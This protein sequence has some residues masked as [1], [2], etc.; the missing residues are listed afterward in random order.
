M[1]TLSPATTPAP[2]PAPDDP[3]ALEHAWL[4]WREARRT[5]LAD[6]HGV[7]SLT[8]HHWLLE[9]AATLDA[10][11]G[12]WWADADGAHV[13]PE[14]GTG[15]LLD[16]AT[17]DPVAGQRDVV[18]AEAGS[19]LPF[20]VA[21][22]GR[23]AE[24]GAAEGDSPDGRAPEDRVAVEL[25]LRTGRYLLRTRDPRSAALTAF[26]TAVE[27]D[28]DTALRTYPFDP[29]QV[30]DLPVRWYDEP[31]ADVV[32]GAK[33]GLVHHVRVVGE[34]DVP[35][36]DGRQA[37]LRVLAGHGGGLT[38]AFRDR[39]ADLPAWR[40]VHVGADDAAAA[41]AS[42]VLRVDLNRASAYPSHFNDHGTCPQPLAGN[43]LPFAVEA[44]EKDPR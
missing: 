41:R 9:T 8:A 30:L 36:P 33:E 26:R 40:A 27:T 31:V 6:P 24:G 20:R 38:L 39:A 25:A 18:V 28:P 16:A 22:D 35:G 12:Q 4:A 42:G 44:G 11:P 34:V 13:V 14:G 15:E 43:D 19:V 5:G 3:A 1:S 17:G 7:L 10:L 29:A 23:A 21:G 2:T 32:D 37:T